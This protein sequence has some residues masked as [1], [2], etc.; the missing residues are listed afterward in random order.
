M[1]IHNQHP[2][3]FRNIYRICI[4]IALAVALWAAF[5][6]TSTTKGKTV[7]NEKSDS[8]YI[9]ELESKLDV[10]DK[11]IAHLE[12]RITELQY[13]SVVFETDTSCN[14]EMRVALLRAG[15][16]ADSLIGTMNSLK[17]RVKYFADG[18][19]EA[20]GR[21]KN[22]TI[23]KSRLEQTIYDLKKEKD[24]LLQVKQ[25]EKVVVKTETIF[26]EKTKEVKR[27]KLI[28]LTLLPLIFGLIIGT[29]YGDK[30]KKWLR[31][32]FRSRKS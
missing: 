29:K 8:S 7:I 20:E 32:R 18:S 4:A 13:S 27:G 26:K 3:E 9:H 28:F 19:F 24:S 25:K 1:I 6:C 31:L 11:E 5:G 22:V 2:N 10:K 16:N 30:I 12:T 23:Q 17:N 14:E 21:L 15:V